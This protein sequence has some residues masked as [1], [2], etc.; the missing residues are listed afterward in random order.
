MG[1]EYD[2]VSD[3]AREGYELGK[4]PW[5]DEEFAE[6][7]RSD[8][9][10]AN[11]VWWLMTPENAHAGLGWGPF[12][13]EYAQDIAVEIV[14]FVSTHP[15]WRV[16]NDASSDIWV[17]TDEEREEERAAFGDE[18]GPDFPRYKKVGSRFRDTEAPKGE[19]DR[20]TPP[21]VLD[22]VSDKTLAAALSLMRKASAPAPRI[23]LLLTYEADLAPGA[24][25]EM[26]PSRALRSNGQAQDLA[27][28]GRFRPQDMTVRLGEAGVLERVFIRDADGEEHNQL[29][30]GVHAS[31]VLFSPRR[32][33]SGVLMETVVPPSKLL[34][35]VHNPT[36]VP[37]LVLVEIEG[38][39]LLPEST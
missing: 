38:A 37:L 14:H 20:P 16:I 29:A 23:G 8:K 2:L 5:E 32:G 21:P 3:L 11:V 24:T 1:I 39:M 6:A 22:D 4:G 10:L 15:D 31:M 17:C 9:P 36:L 25:V 28:L 34:L 18:D 33:F 12:T 26:A 30:H 35:L 19:K 7:L 27:A 13:K